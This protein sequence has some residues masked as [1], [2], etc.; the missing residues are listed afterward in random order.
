VTLSGPG[1]R[2]GSA[3]IKPQ[4]GALVARVHLKA[5][6]TIGA[7]TVESM[8]PGAD[9]VLDD[10]PAGRTP[11]TLAGVRLDQRHRIDLVLPGH[12]IDQ[13]VVLPEKDGVRFTRRLSR[14]D[15]KGKPPPG[16]AAPSP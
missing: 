13:F 10:R 6:S 12:E 9:V 8:P 15:S 16:A 1:V 2:A 3:Q 14:L 7:L 4:P 11:I 5:E